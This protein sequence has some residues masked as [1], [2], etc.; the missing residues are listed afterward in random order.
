MN[1][2]QFLSFQRCDKLGAVSVHTLVAHEVCTRWSTKWKPRSCLSVKPRTSV[3]A[4]SVKSTEVHNTL[5]DTARYAGT[6]AR[7]RSQLLCWLFLLC[8]TKSRCPTFVTQ[9]NPRLQLRS[10]VP[11]KLSICPN[12]SQIVSPM[13]VEEKLQTGD[14]SA[15]R[16]VLHMLQW[17]TSWLL[18]RMCTRVLRRRA[19]VQK[20]ELCVI[21]F[22]V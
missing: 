19:K 8:D 1:Y 15:L 10:L 9:H 4:E 21:V 6:I 13:W 17:C 5:R 18:G 3:G 12:V 14:T 7:R 22:S 11:Q 20:P 16:R 2:L